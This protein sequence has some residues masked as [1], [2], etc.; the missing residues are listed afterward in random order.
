MRGEP[1][2]H[3]GVALAHDHDVAE[4][5]DVGAAGGG[6]AEQHAH[7]RHAARQAHL[8]VED[9]ARAAAAGEH[10]H[11]VG[12]ARAGRVDEVD[13]RHVVAQRLLL[14]AQDLLD[15]LG[16]PGAGLHGRVV[17]HQR[18]AAPADQR[19]AGHDAVGAEAVLV[20]VGEQRLLRERLRV[21]EPRD[22]LAHRDLALV[23]QPLAV[24]LGAA[25]ERALERLVEAPGGAGCVSLLG[26][27][28]PSC[29]RSIGTGF[30]PE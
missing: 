7:L 12:D 1:E 29:R 11:L 22:P 5:R 27:Q 21:H 2:V 25:R 23:G 26:R 16:A 17:G 13:H 10:L 8:V 15:G 6:R 28:S 3:R 20:P 24:L 19:H 9:A 18:D 14:D 4:R 30:S